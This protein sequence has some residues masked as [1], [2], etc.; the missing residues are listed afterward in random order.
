MKKILTTLMF[1]AI[2]GLVIGS[3][4][5][6]ELKEHDFNGQFTLDVPGNYWMA[7]ANADG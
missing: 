4:S 6:T 5:A 1:V 3:V 2:L 7:N